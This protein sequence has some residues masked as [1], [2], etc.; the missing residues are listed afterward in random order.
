M[1]YASSVRKTEQNRDDCVRRL[2]PASWPVPC[3]QTAGGGELPRS[4]RPPAPAF[5]AQASGGES[6]GPQTHRHA[7]QVFI[8]FSFPTARPGPFFFLS[9]IPSLSFIVLVLP[10][11]LRSQFPLGSLPGLQNRAGTICHLA[12]CTI[13]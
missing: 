11:F 5:P 9:N 6:S 3:T 1:F 10:F 8:S 2:S 12:A 4:R 7:A 13:C